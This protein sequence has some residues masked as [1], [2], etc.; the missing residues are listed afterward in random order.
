M[1]EVRLKRAK[2]KGGDTLREE[3][4]L[5]ENETSE[6]TE[7][8]DCS[9][10][11]RISDTFVG[12]A[13]SIGPCYSQLIGPLQPAKEE[14]SKILS[15]KLDNTGILFSFLILFGILLLSGLH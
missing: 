10:V 12:G 8:F 14:K 9:K 1:M 5:E 4:G 2:Y 7:Q 11:G 3:K 6:K 13:R 15:P